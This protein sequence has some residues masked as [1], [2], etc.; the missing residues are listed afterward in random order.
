LFANCCRFRTFAVCGHSGH[1]SAHQ[2]AVLLC[3]APPGLGTAGAPRSCGGTLYLRCA[4]HAGAFMRTVA[5]F[6]FAAQPPGYSGLPCRAACSMPCCLPWFQQ[7]RCAGAL[8]LYTTYSHHTCDGSHCTTT[9]LRAGVLDQGAWF[10]LTHAAE[11]LRV[12]RAYS[13]Y[14]ISLLLLACDRFLMA[15][16]EH[17]AHD[18][19]RF[20]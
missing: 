18:E 11:L 3:F 8:T 13:I 4:G 2:A 7:V 5:R 12:A 20:V 19:Q 15:C 14:Y 6:G 9:Y 1:S 10:V 17:A 16:V